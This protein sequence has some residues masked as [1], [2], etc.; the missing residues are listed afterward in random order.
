MF[1]SG[2]AEDFILKENQINLENLKLLSNQEENFGAGSIWDY[3]NSLKLYTDIGAT[4]PQFFVFKFPGSL[5]KYPSEEIPANFTLKFYIGNYNLYKYNFTDENLVLPVYGYSVPYTENYST[6]PVFKIETKNE[7]YNGYFGGYSVSHKEGGGPIM[8]R[9][10]G[11]TVFIGNNGGRLEGIMQVSLFLNETWF[12][13]NSG[14]KELDTYVPDRATGVYNLFIVGFAT[15]YNQRIQDNTERISLLESWK[16]SIT[17]TIQEIWNA[18]ANIGNGSNGGDSNTTS[19][20]YK[21]IKYLS[22]S[23][24]KKMLC[25]YGEEME[26]QTLTDLGMSCNLTYSTSTSNLTRVG[27]RCK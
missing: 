4:K 26:M 11:N 3:G 21:Y 15:N 16:D 13:W 18:I 27:C 1:G 8:L 24:K 12:G 10:N 5:Y 7:T 20:I 22:N 6:H 17:T 14:F 25:G 23:D 2:N 9:I 19:K